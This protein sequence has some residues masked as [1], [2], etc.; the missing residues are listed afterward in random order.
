MQPIMEEPGAA[1]R[2]HLREISGD[3][4][5][6]LETVG[7]DLRAARLRRGD[8]IATVSRA[9]KIGK[10]HLT[11]LE[12]DNMEN[13]PGKTYAIGFVRSYAGYLG[14][15]AAQMVDRFKLEIAGRH[16][17]QQLPASSMMV[18]ERR[19]PNGW[20]IV[21][22]IVILAIGYGVWHI[23]SPGTPAQT[24]PP[25]PVILAPR[26]AAPPPAPEPAAPAPDQSSANIPAANA[27]AAATPA[28]TPAPVP[29]NPAPAQT[30]TPSPAAPVNAA[31]VPAVPT[32]NQANG[33][34]FGSLNHDA[35]VILKARGDTH[36]LVRGR[37]GMVYINRNLKPGDS[38][39][40][41][42][43]VGLL[44]TTTNAGAVEMNLDGVAM[45]RAGAEL[46][47][48]GDIPLDPQAIADR[49]R[50]R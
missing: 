1:R 41:P 25:A 28:P 39:Q 43:I 4:E 44:L 47:T 32:E 33:R 5:A 22:G 6:P 19:L 13:L 36:I 17:E 35:R 50:R 31:A 9:L 2:I 10:N 11:S 37:D 46:Q 16:D 26:P 15:N 14:L 20:R 21:L 7:Q 8:D 48:V 27:P 34:V 40:L 38:Y 23:L 29:A 45:G 18:E 3:S 42:N 24:V 30:A 49:G 12:E